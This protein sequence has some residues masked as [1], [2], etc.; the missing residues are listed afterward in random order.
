M[1]M[2]KDDFEKACDSIS[3]RFLDYMMVRMGFSEK[4][5]KWMAAC[6]FLGSISVLVNGSPTTEFNME[7]GLRKGD[8]LAPFSLSH[9]GRGAHWIDK[10]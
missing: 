7:K 10:E 3:W 6:V 1:Y 5:R 8:P 2:F 9:G 4:W